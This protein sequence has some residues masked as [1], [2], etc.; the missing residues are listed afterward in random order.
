VT[1]NRDRELVDDIENYLESRYAAISVPDTT[2]LISKH[3]NEE[4]HSDC[5][6]CTVYKSQGYF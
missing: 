6:S 4:W 3:N 2:L 1:R 5:N